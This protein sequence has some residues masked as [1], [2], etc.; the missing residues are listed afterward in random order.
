[1]SLALACGALLVS[2][3]IYLR[4]SW[5]PGL[6]PPPG[7]KPIPILG[8]FLD[9]PPKGTHEF[10]HWLRHKEVYGPI[11]SVTILGQTLVIIHDEAAANILLER[12]SAKTSGRPTFEFLCK[13]CGYGDLLST[14]QYNDNFR[15]GRRFL[16]QQ[17]GTKRMAGQFNTIHEVEVRRFLLRVLTAPESLIEH[18]KM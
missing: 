8:N 12:T 17:L 9:L 11:S 6:K 16:H 2:C 10:Q 1:M 5:K 18:L 15:R 14:Q 4:F 13:L 7:P 3:L